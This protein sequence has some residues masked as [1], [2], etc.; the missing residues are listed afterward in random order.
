M[1]PS[2]EKSPIAAV[3]ISKGRPEV[4]DDT[5]DSLMGQTLVPRQIIV[6]VPSKQDLPLKDRGDKVQHLVGPLGIPV[7][8]NAA[9]DVIPP[10]IR[11]VLFLDDDFE[12]RP[13]YLEIAVSFLEANPAIV[14]FSGR[15]LSNGG[16]TRAQAKELIANDKSDP[17]SDK[18]FQ[19]KG[20]DYILHGCNMFIRRA[21]LSLERFDENLPLYAFGEDYE[22]TMRL[23]HH[24]RVG[25]FAGCIGVHLETPGGRVRE[26]Q[27]GYSLV[28]NNWYLLRKGTVHLSPFM[29]TVRFWS[30]CVGKTFLICFWNL[31]KRDRSKDWAGRIK[32][33]FIA[34]VDMVR[35]KCSPNRIREL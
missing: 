1:S 28:A 22:M 11:Y 25:K 5:L 17:R 19:S 31:L 29:A 30:V 9:I 16:L 2:I 18:T 10:D 4:L 27:R 32:G 7:Q 8:R 21:M 12:L 24:G 33:I 26:V 13:D 15:L 14:A 34:L 6:V 35:G 20:K 3:L 23:E